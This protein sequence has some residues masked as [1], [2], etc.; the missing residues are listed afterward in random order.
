MSF[1]EMAMALRTGRSKKDDRK[2]MLVEG[3][4]AVGG[5]LSKTL[6][7]R[8]HKVVWAE[9]AEEASQ[10]LHDA[11][12]IGTGFDALLADY[13]L[14]DASALRIIRDFRCEFKKAPVALMAHHNDIATA[15]WANSKGIPLL[16]KPLRERDLMKWLTRVESECAAG[17]AQELQTISA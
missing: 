5:A 1:S 17:D 2:I 10:L 8:G 11:I 9:S 4:T 6:A 7:H 3:N 14:A 15:I 13:H 16:E 12:Y